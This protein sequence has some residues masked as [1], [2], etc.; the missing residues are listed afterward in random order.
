MTIPRLP[1]LDADPENREWLR[2]TPDMRLIKLQERL[3]EI[4]KRVS[5]LTSP[6][7]VRGLNVHD[8]S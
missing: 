6:P 7:N 5:V 4:Q 1:R 3:N 2:G 8:N